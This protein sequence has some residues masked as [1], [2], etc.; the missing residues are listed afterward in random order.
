M[1]KPTAIEVADAAARWVK[2]EQ[3]FE[4]AAADRLVLTEDGMDELSNAANDS[5]LNIYALAER[6]A[7]E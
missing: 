5:Y 6:Y 7:S 3:A 1:K 4:D 2:A